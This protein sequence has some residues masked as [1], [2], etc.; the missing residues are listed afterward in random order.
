MT[1]PQKDYHVLGYHSQMSRYEHEE[2]FSDE[3]K[4]PQIVIS[5]N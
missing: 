2:G 4:E 5:H 1:N 3:E